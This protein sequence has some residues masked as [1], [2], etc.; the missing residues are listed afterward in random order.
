[1]VK[2]HS[3]GRIVKYT[4]SVVHLVDLDF[5]IHIRTFNSFNTP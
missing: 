4:R 2:K 5:F 1:M 3:G